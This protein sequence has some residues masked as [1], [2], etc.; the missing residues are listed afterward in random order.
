VLLNL[1]VN[2]RDA[3][4]A[5]G[6]ITITTMS[7][8]PG[9]HVGDRAASGRLQVADTGAGIAEDVLPLI[10]D[11]FFST[12]P[13]ETGAGLGLATIYGIVSQSGGTIVVDSTLAV[14][15]T[16]TVALPAD[17]SN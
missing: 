1:V 17:R 14:G 9:G 8:E 16:M 2:S 15:T 6:T 11:P 7:D 4:D 12:K 5:F 3:I 13:R 10:F